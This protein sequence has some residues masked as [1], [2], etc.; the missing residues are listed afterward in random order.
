VAVNNVI[1]AVFRALRRRCYLTKWPIIKAKWYTFPSPHLAP[2][3]ASAGSVYWVPTSI[4]AESHSC[5]VPATLIYEETDRYSM[6]EYLTRSTAGKQCSWPHKTSLQQKHV[7]LQGLLLA[8]PYTTR[9]YATLGQERGTVY[10]QPSAQ[11]PNPSL[12][13]KK[14]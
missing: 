12:P 1:L 14:N 10:H 4:I 13:S 11:P 5:L 2:S 6:V 8:L 7:N 9:S 3:G